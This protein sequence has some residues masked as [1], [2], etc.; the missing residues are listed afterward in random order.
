M[1][2]KP[3]EFTVGVFFKIRN[4]ID[5]SDLMIWEKMKRS[6]IDIINA[7]VESYL[8]RRHYQVRWFRIFIYFFFHL[9]IFT[10]AHIADI[11]I[12]NIATDITY[13]NVYHINRR[14]TYFV[15]L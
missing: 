10:T 4:C 15:K 12:L 7:T 13:D 9:T 3:E 8:K 1:A 14:V 5:E 11:H 2:S 6:K